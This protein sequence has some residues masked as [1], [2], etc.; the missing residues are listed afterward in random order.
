M[1]A[2]ASRLRGASG[3]GLA[4]GLVLAATVVALLVPFVGADP[5]RDL[6]YSNARVTD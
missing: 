1:G 4:G 6:T 3:A 5:P 2:V